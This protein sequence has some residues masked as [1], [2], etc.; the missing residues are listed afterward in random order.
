MQYMSGC[1]FIVF[2]VSAYL[3]DIL[4][5]CIPITFV[6]ILLAIFDVGAYIYDGRFLLT[7]GLLLLYGMAHIP[8]MY[9]L[10]YAFKLSSTGYASLSGFNILTSQATLLPVTILA[11]PQLGLVSTSKA[12]EWLFLIIF[13]NYSIG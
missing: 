7:F 6:T 9:L 12:L 10:Q 8:Q 5:Y 1:N 11:L 13:P 2:W 3:W 4:N